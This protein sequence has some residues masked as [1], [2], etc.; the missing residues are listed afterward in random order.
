M[1]DP[2]GPEIEAMSSALADGLFTTEP[3]GKA[4]KLLFKTLKF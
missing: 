3:P 2:P 4:S 1:W